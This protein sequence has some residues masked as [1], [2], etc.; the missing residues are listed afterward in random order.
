MIS[1]TLGRADHLRQLGL[2]AFDATA[3]APQEREADG[4]LFQLKLHFRERMRGALPSR[5]RR[6]S[7]VPRV[8]WPFDW[9]GR[10]HAASIFRRSRHREGAKVGSVGL[11][12]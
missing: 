2:T 1:A 8:C 12:A 7:V 3:I 6:R 9:L 11:E 10:T 4:L 5:R